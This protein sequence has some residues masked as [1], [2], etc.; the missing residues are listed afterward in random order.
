M[1]ESV[2]FSVVF[3]MKFGGVCHNAAYKRI[4]PWAPE[5]GGPFAQTLQMFLDEEC[6]WLRT[7][8]SAFI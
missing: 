4:F 7:T 5:F 2:R 1:F 6:F 8:S 3:G